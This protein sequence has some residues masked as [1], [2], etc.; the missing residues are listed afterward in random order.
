VVEP[1]ARTAFDR[2][3]NLVT[4]SESGVTSMPPLNNAL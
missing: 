1:D 4:S 3:V 2:V